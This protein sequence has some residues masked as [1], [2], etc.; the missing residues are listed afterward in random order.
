MKSHFSS[1]FNSI[2]ARVMALL[3]GVAI[4][5][6]LI[7]LTLMQTPIATSVFSRVLSDNASSIAELTTRIEEAPPELEE[8]ILTAYSGEWRVARIEADFEPETKPD[9]QKAQLINNHANVP[10][11]L[12]HRDIRFR[13]HAA[14][15][16]TRHLVFKRQGP[17]VFAASVQQIAIKLDDGRVL[18]IWLAPLVSLATLPFAV[19]S[20]SVIL[21]AII[22][23]VG[24][25]ISWI[26]TGPIKK[27]EREAELVGLSQ[28]AVPISEKGPRELRQMAAALNRMRIRLSGLI[29]ERED[30][31]V[32]MAHDIRT[33][34]TRLKLRLEDQLGEGAQQY[35]GDLALMEQLVTDMLT[36]AR[37]E[38]PLVDPELIT[39][40]EFLADMIEASPFAV[41]LIDDEASHAFTIA[42]SALALHRLFENLIENARRYG[43]GYIAVRLRLASDGLRI[44]VEDDGPGMSHEEREMAFQP[45]FRGEGSR[46][47]ETGGSGLG[48]GIARAIANTHGAHITLDNREEGGL[49]AT[50]FFPQ[51]L[52]T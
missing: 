30:I 22:I 45:F 41:E 46:N 48:L 26:I 15:E 16:M 28:T 36:Y 18:I 37:A 32:A 14:W 38:S 1:F 40:I 33:G 23:V 9:P 13:T 39:L 49:V 6:V 21:L 27:L 34:I 52:A 20:V 19:F 5:V 10:N 50:V 8:F 17:P 47:R 11:A 7:I 25:T 2:S 43:R 44:S 42:G 51:Q 4:I 35:E 24:V 12:A 29:R 3:A 31:V